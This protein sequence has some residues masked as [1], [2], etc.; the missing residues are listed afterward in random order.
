VFLGNLL[1]DDIVFPDG[2]T[3]MGQPGGAIMY[4]SLGAAL[5]GTRVGCVSLVGTDYPVTMLDAL[6]RRRVDLSGVHRLDGPGA[7]TWLLYEGHSRR[8]IHRLGRPTHEQVSPGP[9]CIPR[10]LQSAAAFHLAPMPFSVQRRVLASLAMNANRFVSIDPHLPITE[11]TLGEWRQALADADAFFPSEDELLLDEA[12]IDPERVLPRLA[13]GRLRFIVFKQAARGGILYDA[14]EDRFHR[15]LGRA[16]RVIDPTGAGD[17]F[18]AGF[19][20]AHLEGLPVTACLDRG[21]VSAS[22]AIEAVGAASLLEATRTDAEARIGQ[23]S[24]AGATS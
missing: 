14:R 10:A 24:A 1:V 20:S 18:A 5:W 21:V 7:R 11:E 4:G 19:V 12:N 23:W 6:E 8:L 2:S 13:A 16:T 9:E 22:F 17:A 15:W 3:R